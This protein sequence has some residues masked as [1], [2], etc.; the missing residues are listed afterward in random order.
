MDQKSIN[1]QIRGISN[2]GSLLILIS[3]L[4]KYA[5]AYFLKI[6]SRIDG[7]GSILQDNKFVQL[8]GQ[9]IIFL[10]IYP[11]LY[12]VYYKLLNKKHGLRLGTVFRKSERSKGWIFKWTVISIGVAISIG[13]IATLILPGRARRLAALEYSI[14]SGNDLF[15]WLVIFIP[16]VFLA[17]IFEELIFRGTIFRNNEPMG[18]LFAAVVT[19]ITFGLWHTT[20]QAFS[21]A[22]MGVF[23]CLVFA[24]TRSIYPVIFIH[25]LNNLLSTSMLFIIVQLRG[26]FSVADKEYMIHALFHN[27]LIFSVLFLVLC[28]A[29]GA[30]FIAGP[31]LLIVEIV[32]KRK[33]LGL[34]KGEFP[35]SGWKKTLI[36]FSAP[37]TII[38]FVGMILLTFVL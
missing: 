25:F 38:V 26:I 23:L 14:V 6:L 20:I 15:G 21:A 34:S 13:F 31:I 27:H 3:L 29:Y 18:Q 16:A 30:L 28:L 4:I 8:I 9:G 10:I 22:I 2:I 7:L 1:K 36:F 17:P 24:K 12:L 19:G 11:I 32:K 5:A 37:I 33:G 35:Y